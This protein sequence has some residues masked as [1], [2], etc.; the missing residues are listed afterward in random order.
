VP[1][2]IGGGVVMK[3]GTREGVVGDLVEAV[4]VIDEDARV[5]ELYRPRLEFS[6]RHSNLEG[7]WIVAAGLRLKPSD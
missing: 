2:T 3:R 4:E 6:Y 1:G 5:H 7:K